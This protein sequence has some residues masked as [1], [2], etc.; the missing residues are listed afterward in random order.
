MSMPAA[1]S[2]SSGGWSA[3][4]DAWS[5]EV[6]RWREGF[7]ALKDE[8]ERLGTGL[9]RDR[10]NRP[11]KPGGWS[12]GQCL[13]H[14]NEAG[15]LLVPRLEGAVEAA[16]HHTPPVGTPRLGLFDRFFAW[17][18]GPDGWLNMPSPGSY[19]PASDV[20]D[21][22]HTIHT[23]QALQEELAACAEALDGLDW[24]ARKVI[25]PANRFLRL[26]AGG[27]LE[28]TLAHERR[29]LRQARAAKQQVR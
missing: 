22:A 21:P 16:T 13:D 27:W 4:G 28:A 10:F 17:L 23:F 29:H 15:R 9:S 7:H 14:L 1:G 24:P 26:S 8:A 2:V 12:V 5:P 6:R 18:N 20:L 11:P 19:K 3:A 25:S